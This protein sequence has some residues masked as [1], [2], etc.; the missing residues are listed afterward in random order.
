[1]SSVAVCVMLNLGRSD[2]P[3]EVNKESLEKIQ[4]VS[5]SSSKLGRRSRDTISKGNQW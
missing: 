3:Q 4:Q 5:R 2:L 1:V